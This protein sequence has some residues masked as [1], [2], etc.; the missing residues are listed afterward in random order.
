MDALRTGTLNGPQ[1]TYLNRQCVRSPA[2][3]DST[4]MQLVTTNHMADQINHHHLDRLSGQAQT[5]SGEIR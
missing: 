4:P 3:L 2:L 1:R 5:Y